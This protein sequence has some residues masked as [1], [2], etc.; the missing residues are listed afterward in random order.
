MINATILNIS[1]LSAVPASVFLLS[2]ILPNVTALGR[3]LTWE[4]KSG[5][6]TFFGFISPKKK[7]LSNQRNFSFSQPFFLKTPNS[8]FSSKNFKVIIINVNRA[9][10]VVTKL[11]LAVIIDIERR[12]IDCSSFV[13]CPL[14]APLVIGFFS[15]F[16]CCGRLQ[17]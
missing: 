3:V 13:M 17:Y 7:I 5:L 9:V 12:K 6:T 10:N 16:F 14:L 15:F 1:M 11:F 4:V 8:L 2:D